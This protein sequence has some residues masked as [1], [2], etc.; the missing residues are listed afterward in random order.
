MNTPRDFRILYVEDEED[1]RTIGELC[2]GELGGMTVE[3]ASNGYEA[4]E[5]LRKEKPSLILLDIMM[6]GMDGVAT[7]HAIRRDPGLA[8]IPIA[9]MTAK[10]QTQEIEQYLSMG[11]VAVI[12]KPFDPMALPD[13]VR[14][15]CE[16]GHRTR[17]QNASLPS[18]A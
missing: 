15:L 17:R 6:P 11:A 5:K 9:F 1:I 3:T 12:S 2:L 18:T 10:V 8:E 4:L 13:Q 7:F 14:V 16:S